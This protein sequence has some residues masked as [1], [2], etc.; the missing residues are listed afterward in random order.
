MGSQKK[1]KNFCEQKGEGG[2]EKKLKWVIQLGKKKEFSKI[3]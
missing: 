1:K 3:E 2:K